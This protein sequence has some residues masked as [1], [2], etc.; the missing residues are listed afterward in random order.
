MTG[1]ALRLDWKVSRALLAHVG[2]NDAARSL[3]HARGHAALALVPPG[4]RV[5]V[6][7]EVADARRDCLRLARFAFA[8][9]EAE[10]I[11]A[12]DDAARRAHFYALWTLKEAC[13]KA[14]GLTL[15][16]GL[17]RCVFTSGKAGWQG[18]V[19]TAAPWGACLFRPDSELFLAVVSQPPMDGWQQVEWP[20]PCVRAWPLVARVS[21][22]SVT[23]SQ[24]ERQIL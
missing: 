18:H 7:I 17:R 22:S 20:V 11:A 5:G 1:A 3:S 23:S 4:T 14:F 9:V 19:P 2:A 15:L 6:D 21:Q 16:D 12:L 24:T 13:I 8:P 10:A